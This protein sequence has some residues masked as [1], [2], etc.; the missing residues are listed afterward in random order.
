M[1]GSA[2][3]ANPNTIVVVNAGAPFAAPWVKDVKAIVDPFYP[4]TENGNSIAAILY[5]DANPSGKLPQTFPKKLTDSPLHT[6]QQFPGVNGKAI[7]SEK[8][9]V[10][11]RY[12]D[13][14]GV[15]PEWPFGFGLSYTTF[16]LGDLEVVPGRAST[17]KVKFA[18]RN[19][20]KRSGAEV[21]Q[22]YIGFPKA[23]GEPP[24]QLKGF[25]KLELDAGEKG[26]A[27]VALQARAFSTYSVAKKAWVRRKGC[28]TVSVGNSSRDLRLQGVV[29]IGGASCGPTTT[30]G[31]AT[32]RLVVVLVR[33]LK[34]RRIRSARVYVNGKRRAATHTTKTVTVKLN[35]RATK[36]TKVRIV[37]AT[38]KSRT[39]TDRRSYSP[40]RSAG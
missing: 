28:Y 24:R 12:F 13:A 29:P 6:A 21:G 34:A 22:V 9:E 23:T 15:T 26:A 7:Y 8:L 40:C 4:G 1:V 17:A 31:C 30:R 3:K 38:G 37:A 5:G 27:S 14:H 10:G 18:I 19:T 16:R 11:Y 20:G 35:G 39:V 32:K 25:K 2:V 36:K 33:K